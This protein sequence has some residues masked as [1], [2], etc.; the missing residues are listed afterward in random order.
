[1]T[2]TRVQFDS[3]PS[4]LGRRR[5][6]ELYRQQ[7]ALGLDG[8]PTAAIVSRLNGFG[9]RE[10]RADVF[11]LCVTPNG[12]SHDPKVAVRRASKRD[13]RLA[14]ELCAYQLS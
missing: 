10:S 14:R 8:N 9:D 5:A 1:M 2:E 6:A 4:R 13:A 7:I 3:R 11:C 12:R